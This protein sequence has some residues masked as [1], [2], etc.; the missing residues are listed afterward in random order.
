MS[1][2]P[3]ATGITRGTSGTF[4]VAV[5]SEN[6][7]PTAKDEVTVSLA[8]Q[9]AGEVATFTTACLAGNKTASCTIA[10]PTSKHTVL[11]ASVP[12]KANATTVDHVTVEAQA[13]PAAA[14]L[15]D[16]PTA[17]QTA[18]VTAAVTSSSSSSSAPTSP[19]PGTSGV[20]AANVPIGPLPD[21]NNENSSLIGA[22]NA[23]GL[24]PQ[25]NP[26]AA[27][28]PA[29][30]VGARAG[31]ETADPAASTS[32]LP[33]GMPV[34]TAQIIGLAALALAIML[35]VTRLSLRRRPGNPGQ[36]HR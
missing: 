25:I 28:S 1:V 7:T 15:P 29:P 13:N 14:K 10:A 9:P 6:W 23:A 31:N 21:L 36:H 34:V 16:P 17:S 26:S 32:L 27:P 2:T 22:G 35:A 24:F 33:L 5:W 19:S 8:T 4:T 3:P 30:G 20:G 11:Q 18:Q 12:V